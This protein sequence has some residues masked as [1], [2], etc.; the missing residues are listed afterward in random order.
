MR[1]LNKRADNHD[2]NVMVTVICAVGLLG[3]ACSQNSSGPCTEP[4]IKPGQ[5]VAAAPGADLDSAPEEEQV[6]SVGGDQSAT[7]ADAELEVKN[8]PKRKY[9]STFYTT[10]RS[11]S[12]TSA[13]VVDKG[14]NVRVVERYDYD[15]TG[16]QTVTIVHGT[17]GGTDPWADRYDRIK[18]GM[19][20]QE[21]EQITGPPTFENPKYKAY[22]YGPEARTKERGS[23]GQKLRRIH[24]HYSEEGRVIRQ[25]LK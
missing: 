13:V 7:V 25:W 10:N 12:P 16:N 5:S 3:L 24:V 15:A 23:Q 8:K 2:R 11:G 14:V 4:A 21:V 19:T 22:G 20:R 6:E 9:R 1:S 18:Y 17:D